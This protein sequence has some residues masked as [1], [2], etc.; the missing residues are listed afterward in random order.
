MLFYGDRVR[1]EPTRDAMARLGDLLGSVNASAPGL[2]G[3]EALV[4]AFIAASQL[5]QGVADAEMKA[6]GAD[7]V[8]SSQ[9]AG[10]ALL[11]TLARAVAFSWR[12]GVAEVEAGSWSVFE[13]WA[14]L[15][16]PDEIRGKTAEGYAH[17]AI[18]P[19]ASFEAAA[20]FA[21]PGPPRVLG[22]RSIGTGLATMV[23]V[24]AGARLQP[25]T[26]RPVGPP[27]GRQLQLSGRLLSEILSSAAPF[28]VVDEGPGLSGSSFG[29]V[30]DLLDA[31]G[32]PRDRV[33]YFPSHAGEPGPQ[34][35][36]THLDRWRQARRV[37]TAFDAPA[38]GEGAPARRLDDWVSDL[39][40][41]TLEPK[42]DLSGGRW[43]QLRALD[44]PATPGLERHKFLY[45]TGSGEWLAKFA[46]LGAHG[47]T[48]ARQ[49]GLL[50][51]AGFSPPTAGLRH[52]F[53]I[54]AW[55]SGGQ[56]LDPA[57]HDR[58][59]LLDRLARYL[60]FRAQ[61]FPAMPHDGARM[62]DLFEMVRI[63]AAEALGA[64]T[65]AAVDE[66]L[67]RLSRSVPVGRPVAIDGRLHAWEWIVTPGGRLLKTDAVDHA[68][69]HDLVG[70]QDI[71][72]DIAGARIELDLS[73]DETAWLARAVE[74]LDGGETPPARLAL[75]EALY[76]A[77]Q[78]GLW[79]VGQDRDPENARRITAHTERYR[80]ALLAFAGQPGFAPSFG[81]ARHLSSNPGDRDGCSIGPP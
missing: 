79:T 27:F 21:W 36:P 40:G 20:R 62:S 48:K 47:A 9:R 80:R 37:V 14:T 7:D 29:A 72:W 5:L 38:L 50:A 55:Q 71:A 52:G 54:E 26:L 46:G 81:A 44:A 60:A 77:F 13:R 45:R 78:L 17:Y 39:V 49:A 28:A 22:L 24:G 2:V 35:D 15:R 51:A 33:V 32:V 61:R 57:R 10:M 73:D 16:L 66:R 6:S 11:L 63:N 69:G 8:T 31:G 34:A 19:E 65:A 74:R 41:P 68:Y 70:C 4:A 1:A 12:G 67:A 56:P 43:R 42:R 59:R 23:A 3:H 64:E 58:G 18:Y 30:G 76:A 25:L 53:L 75:H